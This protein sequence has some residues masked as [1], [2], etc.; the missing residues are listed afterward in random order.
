MM[1]KKIA[2]LTDSVATSSLL[3]ALPPGL[4]LTHTGA[5]GA[6]ARMIEWRPSRMFGERALAPFPHLQP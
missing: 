6:E 2:P 1:A 3:T 4:I 5:P